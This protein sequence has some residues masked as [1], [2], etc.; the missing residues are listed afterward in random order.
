[1]TINE[2]SD[3][4]AMA[5]AVQNKMVSPRELVK[6]TISE[7]ERTNTKINAIVSQ[8]YEKAW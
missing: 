8:R 3:V 4:T 7:A 2:W 1:M 5:E 6:D